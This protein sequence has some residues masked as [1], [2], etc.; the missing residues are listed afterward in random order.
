MTGKKGRKGGQGINSTSSVRKGCSNCTLS[1]EDTNKA[2]PGGLAFSLELLTEKV[3]LQ[4]F[5]ITRVLTVVNYKYSEW[6][7]LEDKNSDCKAKSFWPQ[8]PGTAATSRDGALR[9]HYYKGYI[10][11]ALYNRYT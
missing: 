4:L 3:Y 6:Q 8:A 10:H 11:F 9:A 1:A 5:I 7:C 2:H